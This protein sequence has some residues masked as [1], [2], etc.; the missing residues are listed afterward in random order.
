MRKSVSVSNKTFG[1][2]QSVF[3]QKK[4]KSLAESG[5]LV[6]SYNAIWSLEKSKGAK[7]WNETENRAYLNFHGGYGSDPL[8]H[9]HPEIE[10]LMGKESPALFNNKIACADF[11]TDY[12]VDYVETF[13]RVMIP[14]WAKVAPLFFID[15]G[16]AANDN[17][18]KIA[19]DYVVQTTGISEN[20]DILHLSNSFAGRSGSTMGVTNT[21]PHKTKHFSKPYWPCVDYGK[22]YSPDQDEQILFRIQ[23]NVYF[24]ELGGIMVEPIQCEGGDIHLSTNLLQGIQKICNHH[25]IP[26]IVDEIQTGGFSTGLPWCHQHH[27]IQP[28]IV[29]FG[30]KLQQCG[31]WVGPKIAEFKEGAIRTSGRISSTWNGTLVGMTRGKHIMNTIMNN[32]IQENVV[33]REKQFI[34]EMRDITLPMSVNAHNIRGKGVIL[35]FDC[36]NGEE[37]DKLIKKLYD[38]QMLALGAGEKTVRLRP[39]LAVTKDEMEEAIQIIHK[40]L[41]E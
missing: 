30:K 35:A 16:A 23:Q 40:C 17:A 20:T 14:E 7:I 32:K 2:T 37:R 26:F 18:I 31:V 8:G 33:A 4:L 29:T 9:N 24:G 41:K 11:Y 27:G 36:I 15:G 21:D 12:L 22:K 3:M 6:D 13:Q 1:S 38:S 5:Y 19:Q 10:E 28:D 39:N 25:D 34:N